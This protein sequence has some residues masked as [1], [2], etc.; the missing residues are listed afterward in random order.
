M[1][2]VFGKVVNAKLVS[3]FLRQGL[4]VLGAVVMPE[5]LVC[6]EWVRENGAQIAFL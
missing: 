2:L 3:S 6:I 4:D 1:L 5:P